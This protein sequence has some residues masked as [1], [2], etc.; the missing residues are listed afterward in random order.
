M[1]CGVD[2]SFATGNGHYY[3]VHDAIWLA[4]VPEGKLAGGLCLDCLERRL[5][6]RLVRSDFVR[7]PAEILAN[8]TIPPSHSEW[9][10]EMWERQCKGLPEI[11][12][13]EWQNAIIRAKT[14]ELEERSLI[15]RR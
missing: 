3:L 7:T 6:R 9:L 5:N 13:E 11:P 4:A 10:D 2:T 12:F 8:M 15:S 1:D 14:P